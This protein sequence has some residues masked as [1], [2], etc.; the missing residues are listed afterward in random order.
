MLEPHFFHRFPA[1]QCRIRRDANLFQHQSCM[2][3]GNGIVV[4][5]QHFHFAGIKFR[6]IH[7]IGALGIHQRNSHGKCGASPLF[8]FHFQLAVHYVHHVF[9]DG[10]AQTGTSVF[11]GRRRIL[12]AEGIKKLRQEFFTHTDA[13]IFYDKLHRRFIIEAGNPF[14]GKIN[15]ALFR[16]KL[17]RIT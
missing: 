6:F 13:G 17:H 4:N 8:A 7:C 11:I 3:A 2:F 16:C 10:H 5:Y 9:G 14:Y 12:L 1:G 15:M